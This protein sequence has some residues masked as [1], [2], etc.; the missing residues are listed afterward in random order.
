VK[1]IKEILGRVFALWAIITFILTFLII[2]VPSMITWLIPN[3]VGKQFLS[4]LQGCG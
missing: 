2:F 3:P 1:V 4:G